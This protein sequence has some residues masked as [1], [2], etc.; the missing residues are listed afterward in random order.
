[1]HIIKGLAANFAGSHSAYLTLN[2]QLLDRY[3]T[4][5]EQMLTLTGRPCNNLL[6]NP[7]E[8]HG[9]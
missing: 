3:G 1:M 5:L 2:R 7:N 8:Q 4:D 9:N 6:L